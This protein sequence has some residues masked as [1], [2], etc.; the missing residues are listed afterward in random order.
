MNRSRSD[1]EYARLGVKIVRGRR[2]RGCLHITTASGRVGRTGV[3]I[4]SRADANELRASLLP[5]LS[6]A[7]RFRTKPRTLTLRITN[8][9]GMSYSTAQE[10]VTKAMAGTD[11]RFRSIPKRAQRSGGGG[12]GFEWGELFGDLVAAA[13]ELFWP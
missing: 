2:R 6:S 9:D 5:A 8:F 3:K 13:A 10:I 4:S 1:L 7:R 11:I 12:D